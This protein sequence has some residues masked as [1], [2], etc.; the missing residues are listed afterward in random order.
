MLHK[1]LEANTLV[2]VE[3]KVMGLHLLEIDPLPM[4]TKAAA[5]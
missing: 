5:V 4:Q 2:C 1:T 3:G